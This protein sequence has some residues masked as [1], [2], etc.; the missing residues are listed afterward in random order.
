MINSDTPS[1]PLEG[2]VGVEWKKFFNE[3]VQARSEKY[4]VPGNSKEC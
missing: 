1:L 2:R 4:R 3:N